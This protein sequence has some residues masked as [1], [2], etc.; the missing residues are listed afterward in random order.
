MFQKKDIYVIIYPERYLCN[1]L[2]LFYLFRAELKLVCEIDETY[3]SK[4][5]GPGVLDKVNNKGVIKS[6]GEPAHAAFAEFRMTCRF[7]YSTRK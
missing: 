1:L 2:F 7:L 4:L 3:T 6:Y 5:L